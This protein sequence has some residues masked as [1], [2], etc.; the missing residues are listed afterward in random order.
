MRTSCLGINFPELANLIKLA[1]YSNSV[2]SFARMSGVSSAVIHRAMKQKLTS[3]PKAKTLCKIAEASEGRVSINQLLN[4]CGYNEKNDY[5]PEVLLLNP[6]YVITSDDVFHIM[7]QIEAFEGQQEIVVL[8]KD[9]N[10]IVSF[11]QTY[12]LDDSLNVKFALL[13][14]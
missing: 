14:E 8:V 9:I 7:E 2:E 6:S 10:T 4:A 3:R 11:K 12:I 5:F 13:V 1:V